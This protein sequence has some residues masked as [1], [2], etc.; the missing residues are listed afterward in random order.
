MDKNKYYFDSEEFNQQFFYTGELGALWSLEKTTFKIWAPTA[1]GVDIKVSG[2]EKVKFK[3]LKRAEKGVWTADVPGDLHGFKYNYLIKHQTCEF[4]VVDPYAKALSVN[5]SMGVVVDLAR[6]NPPFWTEVCDPILESFGEAIIYEVH[7]RDFSI[8]PD[9]GLKMKG[10]Y[11]GFTELNSKGPGAVL[12]GL[13]HL[14]E[15]G[16]THVQLLP[17]FDY[18]TVDETKPF[19]SY[20]WGYDPLNYNAPEGSYATRPADPFSRI[21]ELKQLI[22]ALRE[23]GIR[24]VMDVVYNHTWKTESANFNQ[25]VPG[26][27]YRQD[28]NGFFSNGSGCG[29]ELATE[30]LMVRKFIID[31]ICYWARE[32]RIKGFR[33][34]LM[35]CYDIETINTIRAQL[36]RIDPSIILYGEGWT[37]GPSLLPENLKA[38]KGQ[39]VKFPG[40]GVFNDDFR[41]GVKGNVFRAES[42]GFISGGYGMEESIKCGITA[43]I[44]HHEVDYKRV[45]YAHCSYCSEPNQSINYIAAH[46]NLT[47][48]DKLLKSNPRDDET[49]QI[50]RQK[51]A[52][53]MVLLSQGVPFL[54]AGQEFCRTKFGD[55]NSYRSGDTINQIVWERKQRYFD[56]FK[57]YQ[58]LIQLR[59]THPAFRL[60][61]AAEINANLH[62]LTMPS[63]LLVGFILKEHA[64]GDPWQKIVVLFSGSKIAREV[65]LPGKNWVMVVDAS[66]AGTKR[67]GTVKGDRLVLPRLATIVLADKESFDLALGK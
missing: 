35:G 12:T 52:G 65:Q 21:L 7:V 37:G 32:Y 3:P 40:V 15:L 59:K 8:S 11:L 20:N 13:S 51:L 34:D 18:A 2:D 5:G 10:L 24:V 48:W 67:I 66:Y 54:H 1:I 47:L 43:A 19:S 25:I 22:H 55:Y 46:D 30:R 50:A 58:G 9:S 39:A 4:E 36:D 42:K 60:K 56:V 61:T 62:F 26:Y 57:Y 28:E 63:P 64:G 17:V 53:A 29:N 16:I 27:Y 49:V 23:S 33:F 45:L 14:I 41:D 31:S 6:T 44:N 38:L